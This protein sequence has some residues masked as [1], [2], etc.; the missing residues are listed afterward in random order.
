MVYGWVIVDADS[1]LQKPLGKFSFA[2]IWQSLQ[3]L[4]TKVKEDKQAGAWWKLTKAKDED[5]AAAAATGKARCG[6]FFHSLCEVDK[7]DVLHINRR[8]VKE[9]KKVWQPLLKKV[10]LA[11][12]GKN[13]GMTKN[14]THLLAHRQLDCF[15]LL[16]AVLVV[17]ELVLYWK[18][19]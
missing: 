15:D 14:V 7:T 4:N 18:G 17:M 2:W 9:I 3:T 12:I 8:R 11:K 5:R 6:N 16:R 19:F 1:A 10:P 13:E